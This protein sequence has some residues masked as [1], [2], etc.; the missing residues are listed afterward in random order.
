MDWLG[1]WHRDVTTVKVSVIICDRRARAMLAR[2]TLWRISV[3]GM[4]CHRWKA[5]H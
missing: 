1:T 2:G 5:M 4:H 3:L